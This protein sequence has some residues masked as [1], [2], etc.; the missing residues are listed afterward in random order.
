MPQLKK[1][2]VGV[3]VEKNA[4]VD[5]GDGVVSF[6]KGLVITDNSEQRNGTKYD[7]KTMDLGEYDGHMTADH[8][9][10]LATIIASVEG[11]QKVGNKVIVSKINY[12]VNDNPLAQLAYN[13]LLAPKLTSNFSIETYGPWPDEEDRTYYN[14]KLIGLS[15]VVVG[16]NKSAKTN[17]IIRNSIEQSKANGLDTTELEEQL[18]DGKDFVVSSTHEEETVS[19]N[20]NDKDKEQQHMKFVTIKNSRD[21]AVKLK[22]KNA[23]GDDVET[24]VA[25]GATTDVSDDQ[26]EAVEKQV[27][28]AKAPEVETPPAPAAKEGDEAEQNAITKAV[29]AAIS[30]L[31]AQ[32]E[33][34]E[35]NQFDAQAAVPTF[36]EALDKER[37]E[38]R[39]TSKEKYSAMDWQDRHAEQINAAWDVLKRGDESRR[40]VLIDCNEVNLAALKKEGIVRNSVSIADFG[41]FVISPELLSE[42]QGFRNDYTA[43]INATTW[44][45]TLST[46]M[47]WLLRNGDISM[48]EVGF[49]DDTSNLKPVSDYNAEIKTSNLMELAAVTPVCNAATRFLAAD[50]LGDVAAGYRNDY[51]RKR[52]QLVV[53]RIQQALNSTGNTVPYDVNPAVEGIVSLLEA[54]KKI[55][56]S[57]PNGT[58]VFN[59]TTHATILEFALR[60]GVNGPL[61]QIFVNGDVP[62]MFGRPYIIVSD[63]LMPSI[64]EVNT[65]QF[66][67]EGQ[68]VTVNTAVFYGDLTKFTGRTSGGLNYDLSTEAAYE[69]DSVVKSAFQRNEL[70]LRGAFFRGGAILDPARFSGILAPG[71]S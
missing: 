3:L 52:A 34:A 38:F 12:L 46:Q 5:E 63:D 21:F 24:E 68:T 2:H 23:A 30:P 51:D 59:S 20:I 17:A 53:A 61:S 33:K 28:D 69:V 11:T 29:E 40:R 47:A 6:P 41:N 9:D 49:L 7:I 60:A 58:F 26:Q 55:A 13:L 19:E 71:V 39:N 45:E 62:T 43:L 1:N 36:K 16:N 32:I 50:L 54:Y 22:Y 4:F 8:T 25:P 65:V 15:Q 18:S 31:R 27:T 64:D 35:Q 42:I 37:N 66:T 44:K 48:D 56:N 14:S 57:T 10:S 67:V 70:V